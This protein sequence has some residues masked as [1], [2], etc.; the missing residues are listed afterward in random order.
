MTDGME[1]ERVEQ[2]FQDLVTL[3]KQFKTLLEKQTPFAVD[4]L[5]ALHQ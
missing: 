3:E 4:V 1:L 2:L 5:N